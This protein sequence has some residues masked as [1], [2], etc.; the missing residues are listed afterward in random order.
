[1]IVVKADSAETRRS[2]HFFLCG[3]GG[4]AGAEDTAFASTPSQVRVG[5]VHLAVGSKNIENQ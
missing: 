3:R 2:P 4:G 5:T 1:M